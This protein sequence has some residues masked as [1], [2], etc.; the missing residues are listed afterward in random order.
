MGNYPPFSTD[1][2]DGNL[3]STPASWGALQRPAPGDV[4]AMKDS[5]PL[6]NMMISWDFNGI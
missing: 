1:D 5:D 2:S 4:M 6:S 3:G